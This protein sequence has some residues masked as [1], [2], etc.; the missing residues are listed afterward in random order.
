MTKH[1][2]E[3]NKVINI[4]LFGDRK[5][6]GKIISRFA[7]YGPGCEGINLNGDSVFTTINEKRYLIYMENSVQKENP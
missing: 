4:S 1:D 6:I 3:G 5:L 2:E 7:Q